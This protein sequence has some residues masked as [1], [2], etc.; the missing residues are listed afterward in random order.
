MVYSSASIVLCTQ[1]RGTSM[2]LTREAHMSYD[3]LVLF[4]ISADFS[5]NSKQ[6]TRIFERRGNSLVD[7]DEYSS[8]SGCAA[9]L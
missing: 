4:R 5:N 6:N 3:V 2:K 8:N 1:Y 7:H 9:I